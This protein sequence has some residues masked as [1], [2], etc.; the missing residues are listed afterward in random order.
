MAEIPCPDYIIDPVP[1]VPG[2]I[3]RTNPD[4]IANRWANFVFS[5]D[6]SPE[7]R[8]E[9]GAGVGAW[10]LWDIPTSHCAQIDDDRGE[11]LIA[12]AIVDRVYWLD[13]RRYIDE[14]YWN[15]YAPIHRLLRIGPI[16]SNKETGGGGYD[17]SKVKR[18]WE[19]EFSLKDGPTGAAG[20]IWTVT[21]AEW[22]REGRTARSGQRRTASRMRTKITTHGR[23]FIV[24]LEHSANEPVR[25]EHWRAAWDVVGARIKEAGIVI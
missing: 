11:D 7:Q 14:W 9:I 20:A 23:T 5:M 16:P 1:A 21:V 18:F 2:R 12:I 17:L 3:H 4:A 19:F 24:T 6:L 13:W 15:S 10:S 22:D 25:I 8:D